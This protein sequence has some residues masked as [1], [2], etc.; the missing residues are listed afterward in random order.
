MGTL[1]FAALPKKLSYALD[2]AGRNVI[3]R[4]N[5]SGYLFDTSNRINDL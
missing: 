4:K 2:A 1:F 3:L 5:F